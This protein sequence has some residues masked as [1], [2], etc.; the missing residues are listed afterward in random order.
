MAASVRV[1]ALAIRVTRFAS[2][3]FFSAAAFFVVAIL[4]LVQ[5]GASAVFF[6]PRGLVVH[7]AIYSGVAAIAL[8]SMRTYRMIWRYVSFRD[9]LSIAG[10]V[11]VTVASFTV[12]E[13]LLYP[14]QAPVPGSLLVWT[15][16]ILWSANVG[17]LSLPRFIARVYAEG[18]AAARGSRSHG[19]AVGHTVLLTGEP[20]RVDAFIRECQRDPEGR[21]QVVGVLTDNSHIHGSYMHGVPV[22]DDVANL[23]KVVA[24]LEENGS[25]PQMLVLAKDIPSRADLARL[26]E[27]TAAVN[28]KL[29]RLPPSGL[30]VER[31]SV[32]PIDLGDLLRRPEIHINSGRIT[33][34]IKGK[35]VLITGAGGSIGSELS[36]QVAQCDPAR[37]VILDACEFNLYSIDKELD[38]HYPQVP[39]EVALV[40]VRDGA[41]VSKWFARVRPDLVFHAAALKHV[42]LLESHPIEA[43]KTNVLG[44]INLAEACAAN[45][46][47]AMVTISTDKAVNPT[48]V[49]GA[50][51][52]LAEAYCQGLDQV[53]ASSS[54]TRFVTVR[55]G[56]VLG[57]AGSV[58]PLFQ[59]QI[60]CGGPVT[61]THPEIQ[62]YFMTI[63]EAVTLVL[64]AGAQGLDLAE[65]RGHI[66]LLD[67]GEP[68][69]II[70]L[71]RQMIRLSGAQPD[72]DIKIKIIGLRPGEKLYEETI[73]TEESVLPTANKSILKLAPRVTD[74]RIIR[75]QVQELRLACTG[76]DTER[77]LR[78]LRTAV[79]DYL[80]ATGKTTSVSAV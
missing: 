19:K 54:A 14:P 71:A 74:L 33:E 55:F 6:G 39:R 32:V 63:P 65:D 76:G 5:V 69:K 60:E 21:F 42:P 27:L 48:N 70:D 34:L 40:D 66:Y 35:C 4:P 37:L 17:L 78:L 20:L 16:L 13:F 61:V 50:T 25:R 22:I 23:Q 15:L 38:E 29:G 72:L 64:Q 2:D 73:H 62:R 75:Q 46:V 79:P 31:T 49:M 80:P 24:D 44:T 18:S 3:V 12:V 53:L 51:K 56:N 41:L 26:V 45:G 36:R 68:V 67:M 11:T 52:R 10:A 47:S 30:A 59:R 8:A 1:H 7:L 28:I 57:S 9:F 77:T 58:V 43:V